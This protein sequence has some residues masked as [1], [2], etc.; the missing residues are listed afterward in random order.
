MFVVMTTK[1]S[2]LRGNAPHMWLGH[3]S[4]VCGNTS[5]GEWTT[6]KATHKSNA[7]TSPTDKNGHGRSQD[8]CALNKLPPFC[9]TL[10][11]MGERRRPD[12]GNVLIRS[13]RHSKVERA[14][15]LTTHEDSSM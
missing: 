2:P 7:R 8:L 9:K 1:M 11:I 14:D 6:Q 3:A 5:S 10:F 4:G 13:L 12:R 15:R